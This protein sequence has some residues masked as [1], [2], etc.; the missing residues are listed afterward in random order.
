MGLGRWFTKNWA[1]TTEPTHPDLAPL[2]VPLG[3]SD[4]FAL[5]RRA[6]AALPRWSE[7]QRSPVGIHFIRRTRLWRF[8]D[9][10]AVLFA[11]DGLNRTL[12]HAESRSRI[13]VGDLGQN[14]RNIL[15]LFAAV[16]A[17]S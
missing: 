5:V 1:N 14:R 8:T 6:V 12:I 17:N 16:R 4:A 11:Q 13:G 3:L 7:V 10:V 9:D 2:T 15:E